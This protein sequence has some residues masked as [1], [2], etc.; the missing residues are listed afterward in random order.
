MNKKFSTLMAAALLAGS[1][2]TANATYNSYVK[3]T[4]TKTEAVKS[5]AGDQAYQLKVGD[6]LLTMSEQTDGTMKLALE[7]PANGVDLMSSLWVISKQ[8][9]S[10]GGASYTFYNKATGLPLAFTAKDAEYQKSYATNA[11]GDVSVWKWKSGSA[12][13]GDACFYSNFHPD[14]ALV[15][16]NDNDRVVAH[17]ILTKTTK[18]ES[19]FGRI[20][21]DAFE[22]VPVYL[23]VNALNSMLGVQDPAKGQMQMAFEREVMNSKIG[24]LLTKNK[25]TAVNAVATS[26]SMEDHYVANSNSDLDQAEQAA[27]TAALVVVNPNSS[28]SIIHETSLVTT[29]ATKVINSN[30]NLDKT[31]KTAINAELKASV[32]GTNTIEAAVEAVN[33]LNASYTAE[34]TAAEAISTAVQAFKDSEGAYSADEFNKYSEALKLEGLQTQ[35]YQKVVMADLNALLNVSA[36][37]NPKDFIKVQTETVNEAKTIAA[38]LTAVSEDVDGQESDFSWNDVNGIVEKKVNESILNE[39]DKTAL[40]EA[41]KKGTGEND[42]SSSKSKVV[43]DLTI[44][45][46]YFTVAANAI[47][48]L[49]TPVIGE[50]AE[51]DFISSFDAITVEGEEGAAV[52]KAI[53]EAVTGEKWMN[54]AEAKV[55]VAKLSATYAGESAAVSAA[56]AAAEAVDAAETV[57]NALAEI[58]VNNAN[59]TEDQ[60]NIVNGIKAAATGED[61]ETAMN[62]AYTDL[63]K[64]YYEPVLEEADLNW[65]SLRA[66]K[67]AKAAD[68]TYLM[69]DTAYMTGISGDKLLPFNIRKYKDLSGV[70]SALAKDYAG[71]YNFKFTY[72]P[73]QDSL[74][75]QVDGYSIKP[76][77]RTYWSDMTSSDVQTS[78]AKDGNLVKLAMLTD[79]H[80]EVTVGHAE[81]VRGTEDVTINTRIYLDAAANLVRTTLPSGVYHFNLVTNET[82]RKADNG[83]YKVA[84]YAGDV[85][86]VWEAPETTQK[87][88]VAQDFNYIPRTQWVVEQN[89]GVDGVET[90]NI[91]NREFPEFN[92]KNVQLYKAGDNVFANIGTFAN[93]TLSFKLVDK[94]Y[95]TNENLGYKKFASALDYEKFYNLD[96]LSGIEL[97]NYVNVTADSV[98]YVDLNDG[99][100]YVEFIPTYEYSD[101]G[102]TSTV[103]NASQLRR[104]A[105]KI[106]VNSEALLTESDCF[107][108]WS[109]DLKTFEVSSSTSGRTPAVFML[110]ENNELVAEDGTVTPY[111]ALQAIN[112]NYINGKAYIDNDVDYSDRVGVRDASMKFSAE[113]PNYY[114][115]VRV[116]AFAVVEDTTPLY[117]RLGETLKEDGFKDMD[118]QNAKIYTVNSTEK[119]Y[120]Y[121]DANS[122]YSE[123]LGINFLGIESKGVNAKSAMFVDTAYVRNNTNMPQYM[124]VMDPQIVKADTIWCDA[125]EAHK[126]ETKEEALACPHTTVIPASVTGRYLINAQ[127]SVNAGNK[128]YVWNRDYTRLAFVEAKHIGDTLVIFR[129]GKPSTAAA[130]SIFLGNNNHN[131]KN[132]K[133]PVFAFRLVN[134]DACDFLIETVGDH[135]IPSDGQGGWVAVKNGV[136]VVARYANYN[137]AIRDAEIFN[138]EATDEE[139]TA[140]ETISAGNVVVAGVDGAVVV[141]GAEG[142]NVIVST[143]LGK[144]VANEVVSSDNAT[145]AAP[146]GVVVVSVDGES[147]KVVVK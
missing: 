133:N 21:A 53:K 19:V 57:Q 138:I 96:Y 121:E 127:D 91:T 111:Y 70:N 99:K 128:D 37:Y 34:A 137:D 20:E 107:I 65:V 110:K 72:Y 7:D 52:K 73:T 85:K 59:F 145:I 136:P 142:K 31:Q 130:D 23:G 141:K 46:N 56:Y 54:L 36:D 126:H 124:L 87:F 147:F 4:E 102:Y 74:D 114:S 61:A 10:E 93:D 144:V 79:N 17:K 76:E 16:I 105:Y 12:V 78:R 42:I 90:V 120:L 32:E 113:L 108:T 39:T 98:V 131:Y 89:E 50:T 1:V 58:I 2:G 112:P 30:K 75:V 119:E 63:T 13:K 146:Q 49:G 82:S 26:T 125:T 83:K 143:I 8:N 64:T 22:A 47:S 14:S 41:L 29:A 104:Q 48:E 129:N 140:N 25:Y 43:D 106:R 92:Y 27:V 122:K 134:T 35:A 84:S 9:D 55:I 97:G 118:V 101:F 45:S 40:I 95:T 135:K 68:H 60:I 5:I 67:A 86:N 28:A 18:P 62:N 3:V 33:T 77:T 109:K 132:S 38:L 94:K 66:T 81:E 100:T 117:R 88:G 71:R 11:V 116:A 44:F 24:N 115:E 69:V 139:A 15:L 103:A 51:A 80:Y 6:R 123:G